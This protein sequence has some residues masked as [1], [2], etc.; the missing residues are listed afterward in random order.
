MGGR[1][2]MN[3]KKIWNNIKYHWHRFWHTFPSIWLCARFPFLYPRNRFTGLHYNNW[4]IHDKLKEL[5]NEAYS[6]GGKEDGFKMTVKN[7]WKWIQYKLL[8]LYHDKFL[9]VIF[10]WPTYTELDAMD[11][12]WRKAFGIQMCKEI[13]DALLRTGGRKALMNYRIA[14]IKEKWGSLVWSDCG[15]SQE[16]HK[17]VAK[18]EY[19]SER[20]CI[21]C[22][23]PAKGL[24]RGWICPYCEDCAGD[25]EL[26]EY[27][28]E[29]M[30][31]YGHYMFKSKEEKENVDSSTNIK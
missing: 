26:D 11:T 28:T 1:L 14:Q 19:I 9:Q 5:V 21:S 7:R 18:Y 12:G 22:G 16:V 20:T 27:Y 2:I 4:K 13:K 29:E 8:K 15:A 10:W 24:S 3:I 25:Q 17:V 31:W 23:R 30:P 6:F